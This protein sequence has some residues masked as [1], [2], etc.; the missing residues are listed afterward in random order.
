MKRVVYI[1]GPFR[2]A[3]HWLI[4]QNIRRAEEAALEVWT[5]GAMAFCPHLNT[6]HFQD[7]LPDDTWLEGDIEI[8]KRCDAVLMVE[9]WT[10][11][12][13]AKREYGVAQEYE[14]PCFVSIDELKDWL[15]KEG[16]DN[17]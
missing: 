16:E 10:N 2:A 7:V 9:G 3:N 5:L 12:E 8:L 6:A 14:I 1:A 4:E 13:G 11:S 15:N 17:A